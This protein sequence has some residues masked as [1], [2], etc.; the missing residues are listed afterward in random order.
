MKV[1]T[2]VLTAL[3]APA[4]TP[5]WAA[6]PQITGGPWLV[7]SIGTAPQSI[8]AWD[9][10]ET[11]PLTVFDPDSNQTLAIDLRVGGPLGGVIGGFVGLLTSSGDPIDFEPQ[12][13][14]GI[15][16]GTSWLEISATDGTSRVTR[17]INFDI[18]P[19][20]NPPQG[21]IFRVGRDTE[22]YHFLVLITDPATIQKAHNIVDGHLPQRIVTGELVKGSG[23]FNVN[24]VDP[25]QDPWSWYLM[26]TTVSFTSFAIEL[27]DSLPCG[28]EA[29]LDY[30]V[31][32]VHSYCPWGT[33]L[34]DY[35]PAPAV[36]G[37]RLMLRGGTATILEWQPVPPAAHY[38]VIRGD[39][40]ELI[41]D[42]C[43]LDL[44]AVVCLRNDTPATDTSAN[45]DTVVPGVGQA[46]FYLVRYEDTLGPR[47][48]GTS[49]QGSFRTPSSGGCPP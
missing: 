23:G 26:P 7:A 3:M 6:P 30:W 31:N 28:L 12:F 37:P 19:H 41:Q 29:D 11:Y 48:Y 1:S 4:A 45:P 13:I 25:E 36:S 20:P 18:G 38:D 27:C 15:V 9:T 5:L 14:A 49:T 44:G 47:P 35:V 24:P 21:E 32:S 10:S 43:A 22:P 42:Y 46:F 8:T 17:F 33:F 34:R 16:P 40:A 39:L 2:L